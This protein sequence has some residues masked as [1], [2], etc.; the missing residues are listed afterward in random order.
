VIMVSTRGVRVKFS[1]GERVLCY[2]PDP[3]KAKVL[4]DSKV[5]EVVF[6]KDG[7]GR[8]QIEYLIHFQGWNASWDRCVSEDFVLKD[9]D[10]NRDLQRQLADKAQIKL[11]MKSNRV[12]IG[13]PL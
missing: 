2:E 9:T 3:T 1:E 5:L 12:L 4:Y 11:S 6:N 10:E 7:K 13:G 8:K